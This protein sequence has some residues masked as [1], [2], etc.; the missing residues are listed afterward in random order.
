MAMAAEREER[1]EILVSERSLL[2]SKFVINV[3]RLISFRLGY[4]RGGA[5][6][7]SN[8]FGMI[9]SASRMRFLYTGMTSSLT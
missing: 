2:Q 9:R 1:E 5:Y 3:E 6:S 8:R 4:G 7:A